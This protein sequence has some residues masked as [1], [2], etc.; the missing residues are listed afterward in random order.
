MIQN[1]TLSHGNASLSRTVDA[2]GPGE[3]RAT[4]GPLVRLRLGKLNAARGAL[5]ELGTE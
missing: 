4:I 2:N 5:K 3:R 1:V